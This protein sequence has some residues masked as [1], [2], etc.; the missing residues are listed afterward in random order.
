MSTPEQ[1]QAREDAMIA[2]AGV[3]KSKL[4]EVAA[5]AQNTDA[6]TLEGQTL[7]QITASLKSLFQGATTDTTADIKAIAEKAAADLLALTKADVDLGSVV[8][9]GFVDTSAEANY[10]DTVANIYTDPKAVWAIVNKHW[11]NVAGTAPEVLNTINEVAAAIQNNQGT[12]Q[13]LET[14]A[15]SKASTQDLTDAVT[16]LQGQITGLIATDAE[17]FASTATDKVLSVKQTH[18]AIDAK[19]ATAIASEVTTET[20]VFAQMSAI[21]DPAPAQ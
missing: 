7:T 21:V 18:D 1:L 4:D 5:L 12:I 16:A 20:S 2:F 13:S 9:A 15:A 8:N 19:I 6:S 10:A 17:A 14:I 3:V 11:A